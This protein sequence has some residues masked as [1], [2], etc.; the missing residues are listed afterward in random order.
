MRQARHRSVKRMEGISG[1]LLLLTA[2]LVLAGSAVTAK[3]ASA[4]T[5]TSLGYW[6][7][8]GDGG[9]YAFGTA[10]LG[11]MRG[12][13]LNRPV[14]GAAATSSGLGYWMVAS[15]GGIFTFGDAQFSGS[16]G[17]TPLNRPIVGMAVDPL[18]GGYWLVAADGGIFSFNAPFYGSTGAIHLNQPVVG[19]AATPSGHGYWLVAADGG[20]FTF[21]DA[22][23]YGSMGATR[24]NRPI[25]GMAED[26]STGG[27]WL[28][29]SDGGIF[30]FNAPFYGS[31]G[32]IRLNKPVVG[33]STTGEG[34]GYWL[35]ASDGGLFAF[36]AP[37]LGSTGSYPGPA[38][39]VSLMSTTHGYPF[40]PGTTGYD[41][42]KFQCNN[43]PT[44]PQAIS[45]VQVTGGAINNPPN[46]CYS[47][48][49]AWAGSQMSAYVFM[50]G[51]PSPAPPESLSGPA[52]TCGGNVNCESYNFGWNWANHWAAYSHGAGISP[53]FWWLDIET[54]GH[55][56]LNSSANA[57]NAYVIAGA[58]DALRANGVIAGIYS[59]ALQW[60]EITGNSINFPGVSLWVPGASNISSGTY[61]AQNIC[62]GAVPG[63]NGW[64]YLPFA[65]GKI[66][67]SQYGYGPEYTG[68]PPVYDQD[69]A[70]A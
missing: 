35:V 15:D 61:S 69:Y 13:P 12:H 59:T 39:I 54:A 51:L 70:C 21:G 4:A 67:L 26:P 66:V 40:P 46:P 17:A 34:G 68:P 55:W 57:S 36:N 48:E 28:V 19:M 38:P 8:A 49:A 22:H 3:R 53:T 20:V 65:Q 23:F 52:G 30:S 24:L 58:L 10:N 63:P 7:V 2:L 32:S 16:M 47:R 25:V 43:I 45:I 33:M 18:T 56:N 5:S 44:T 41:I 9:V 37:Y 60:S 42:S 6:L 50:D 62:H 31:T 14:V 1:A 11:S 29:A 27:Y 64:E